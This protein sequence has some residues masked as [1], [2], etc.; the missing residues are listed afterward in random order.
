MPTAIPRPKRKSTK[1]D[2][3]ATPDPDQVLYADKD[4]SGD[5]V[6][7]PVDGLCPN[8]F[9]KRQMKGVAE[10][11]ATIANVG[12]LQNIAHVPA[13]VW[14]K[15]YPETADKI[16]A[17]HVI[18]FGEHRWRAVRELGW[19]TIPSV[20]RDDK[21]GEARE[22]TLIE[23][24]RRAQL[25]PLEEA[26]HYRDLRDSGMSYDKIAERVGETAKGSISKGTVWKRVKLLELE[27]TCLEALREGKLN[28]S[29]AEKLVKCSA[30]QQEAALAL[31]EDGIYIDEALAR[32]LTQGAGFPAG[33]DSDSPENNNSVSNGNGGSSASDTEGSNDPDDTPGR[34][35]GAKAAGGRREGRKAVSD[36]N[37]K[38]KK[39]PAQRTG[40][41]APTQDEQRAAAAAARDAACQGL[42]ERIDVTD[43][44]SSAIVLDVLTASTLA[45][46]HQSRPAQQRALTW[47]TNTGRQGLDDADSANAGA[48]F[49]AVLRS[50]DVTLQRLAAFAS[51]LAVGELRTAGRRQSWGARE[52]GHVR[53]LQEHAAY[54]PETAWEK[55][56]LGPVTTGGN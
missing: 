19:K 35:P 54:V 18:L 56:Q 11:A 48:Y 22:I 33:A 39:P 23:N 30:E 43:D 7:L 24:L 52:I 45:P 42:I 13:E 10:L 29:N 36:G 37:G 47:L 32:V 15:H 17:E 50:D 40:S 55:E 21:V 1:K 8:P 26:E 9:N 38:S 49:D 51:A 6:D 12:L 28:P 41:A 44:T 34:R 53:L 20:L 27:P 2:P 4:R 14:L 31:I 16:T 46:P 25:S 5:T 3:Q